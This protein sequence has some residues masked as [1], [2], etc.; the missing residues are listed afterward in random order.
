MSEKKHAVL[1]ASSARRWI[2]CPPSALACAGVK[3]TASEYA[4][5]GTD[6]HSLCEYKLLTALGQKAEDPTENLTYFDEEMAD[7]ADA[8]AEFVQ[9][10][11]EAAKQKCADPIVL[12]E[13]RLDFSEYVPDGFGTGDC[14]IVGDGT[15]SVVDFK[16]G[17]GIVVEA[18]KNPQMMC[19]ALGVLALFD[20]IY[21]IDTVSMTIFQPRRENVSTYTIPKE[22]LLIWAAE[23]LAPTAQLAAKGDGEYRAG[24]HC[25]FC[26]VKT[27]CRK[28]A[29]YNLELARYDFEPPA[30]LEDAEIEAV[31]AKVDELISW[32]GDV[33]EY[34]LQAALQGKQW[35]DW[36]VVEG[37]S[38][39]KYT[40][41]EAVV[42]TVRDA[43]YD[44]YEH[45]V[46][47]ITAMTKL[48]GK[49]RFEELLGS[50]T[51]KPQGKPTLVPITDKRP[52]MNTA[53]ED[54]KED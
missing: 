47:G 51:Y 16:Y 46:L 33:K 26:K 22:E 40:N 44:P 32:A 35:Q 36:K 42:Q 1:S 54:F 53:A 41:D 30:N 39:R 17:V 3:D 23:V 34:A 19:Y 50:L 20:G 6:A 27:T 28:R 45:K 7:C 48:L 52:V 4:Q 5:Q 9:E 43:G 37:R 14:V 25:Q 24:E 15:L 8:Y 18:E 38:N 49:G 13:Q 21:D 11:V 29:E 31:L 10:Q 12:V 2:A